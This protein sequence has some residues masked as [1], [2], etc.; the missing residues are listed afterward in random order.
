M[1]RRLRRLVVIAVASLA[2]V[3]CQSGGDAKQDNAPTAPVKQE[4]TGP[5]VTGPLE[6][7]SI[8]GLGFQRA[9]L[10]LDVQPNGKVSGVF[11]GGYD[12]KPFELFVTG[13]VGADGVLL[14]TGESTDG[15]ARLEGPL[16]A[17][18]FSGEVTGEIFTEEFS[19]PMAA[20]PAKQADQDS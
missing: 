16:E 5:A 11:Q 8:S 17:S 1:N 2:L 9:V 4:P 6:S 15:R 12:D 7:Q 18:G 3:G 20:P 19:L 10:T 13:E 14:A